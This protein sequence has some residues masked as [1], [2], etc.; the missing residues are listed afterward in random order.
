MEITVNPYYRSVVIDGEEVI[1]KVLSFPDHFNHLA[2]VSCVAEEITVDNTTELQIT[3]VKGIHRYVSHYIEREYYYK[4]L[5][6]FVEWFNLEKQAQIDKTLSDIQNLED[7]VDNYLEPILGVLSEQ[8]SNNNVT[9]FTYNKNLNTLNIVKGTIATLSALLPEVTDTHAGLMTS[10]DI[11]SLRDLQ[12]KVNSLVAQGV[13]RNTFNTY[14]ELTSTFPGLDITNTN[15]NVNDYIYIIEDENYNDTDPVRTSYIVIMSGSSKVLEFR[16]TENIE[17]VSQATNDSF[18]V[19][20]GTPTRKGGIYIETNG[21]MSLIGWDEINA[22]IQSLETSIEEVSDLVKTAGTP[23]LSLD[24]STTG[25][26]EVG[27]LNISV[28]TGLLSREVFNKAWEKINAADEANTGA[29]ISDNEWLATVATHGVCGKYSRGDGSTNFRTPLIAKR[30]SIGAPDS[31]VG[32]VQG[33]YLEDQMRP[34]TGATRGVSTYAW[35]SSVTV[36]PVGAFTRAD[37]S[38]PTTAH[39]TGDSSYGTNRDLGFNSALLGPH[40]SGD[41]THGRLMILTPMLKL[42]GSMDNPA[43][44]NAASTLQMLTGKLDIGI[45]NTSL[46]VLHV[47][48]EKPSTSE[49]GTFTS[50]AWRTR[51][52]NTVVINT[53]PDASLTNNQVTLPAGTY[54]LYAIAPAYRVDGHKAVIYNVTTGENIAIGTPQYMNT[55]FHGVTWSTIIK[56]VT[57][58]ESTILELRHR[59]GTTQSSNGFGVNYNEGSVSIYSILN[60]RRVS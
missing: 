38:P 15:W 35:Y 47:R 4:H 21:E 11:M 1:Q 8:V 17:A 44:L 37:L 23:L 54:D 50:G 26:P 30:V 29:V 60:I 31:E 2:S 16:R 56:R 24:W 28:P 52:L 40:Y 12:S 19:V 57:F 25:L 6:A 18:G 58:T 46:Q 7:I 48:D 51:D 3:D 5:P 14:N 39:Y 55:S 10:S 41:I 49:G 20:K 9:S 45:F 27:Y 42:Y 32:A 33:D 22:K 53:I 59:A 13:W 43:L 36:E 34:I